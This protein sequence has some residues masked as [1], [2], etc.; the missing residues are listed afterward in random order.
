LVSGGQKRWAENPHVSNAETVSHN[1]KEHS[2]T[3]Q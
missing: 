2:A 1:N 3:N